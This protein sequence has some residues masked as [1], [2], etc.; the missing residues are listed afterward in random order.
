MT[1]MS[2]KQTDG[3]EFSGEFNS[4]AAAGICPRDVDPVLAAVC[5]FLDQA[6]V[7]LNGQHGAAV[8]LAHELV[9]SDGGGGGVEVGVGL[10]GGGGVDA[11][12]GGTS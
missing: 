3:G 1:K 11:G 9:V 12:G 7:L 5:V 8:R 4:L 10:W 6:L 2:Q